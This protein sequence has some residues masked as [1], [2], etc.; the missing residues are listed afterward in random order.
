[1]SEGKRRPPTTVAEAIAQR[2]ERIRT[3]PEYAARV[4]AQE[5]ARAAWRLSARPGLLHSLRT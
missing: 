3:D 5:A 2:E 1:M 4:R